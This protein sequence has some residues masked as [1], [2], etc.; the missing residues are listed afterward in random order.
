MIM[1]K[2]PREFIEQLT[3]TQRIELAQNPMKFAAALY[4]FEVASESN[5]ALKTPKP[6]SDYVEIPDWLEAEIKGLDAI[7][8]HNFA[9]DLVWASRSM[10]WQEQSLSLIS[11]NAESWL[12][13]QAQD[14]FKAL[15]QWVAMEL[16]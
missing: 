10:V 12:K 14:T 4:N 13:T 15:L 7:S 6:A 8:I 2:F 9:V 11:D 3:P 16:I 1:M 5:T